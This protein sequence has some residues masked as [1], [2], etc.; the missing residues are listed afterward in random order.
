MK[1]TGVVRRQRLLFAPLA[2]QGNALL[3]D[4][5]L[6]PL[7]APEDSVEFPPSSPPQVSDVL[8]D[9]VV[10]TARLRVA[11]ERARRVETFS[12][13]QHTFHLALFCL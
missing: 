1:V 2:L 7:V 13:L 3:R 5:A 10:A 12:L 4:L 8:N 6:T 9:L 11:R